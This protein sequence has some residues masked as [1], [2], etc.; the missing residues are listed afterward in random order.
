M[1]EC[2]A[3]K[4]LQRWQNMDKT[5]PRGQH[6]FANFSHIL[7]RT[8]LS[9]N[10]FSLTD[11]AC[12]TCLWKNAPL[13]TP[14]APWWDAT[15]TTSSLHWKKCPQKRYEWTPPTGRHW[16]PTA[17]VKS[18]VV[19]LVF[20]ISNTIF[21]I[22]YVYGCYCEHEWESPDE[23]VTPSALRVKRIT[24]KLNGSLSDYK[25]KVQP[26]LKQS[27]FGQNNHLAFQIIIA[28]QWKWG[29]VKKKERK[30]EN[31]SYVWSLRD[32]RTCL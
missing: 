2:S 7:Q 8:A 16:G 29:T 4:G 32:V 21:L 19:S 27:Q 13:K 31:V 25:I 30:K 12:W 1:P 14:Y 28:C 11:S 3:E 10:S 24:G 17:H 22:L 15:C 20:L 26:Q 6:C 5:H 18:L 23:T 9:I